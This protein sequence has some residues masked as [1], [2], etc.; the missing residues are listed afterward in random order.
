MDGEEARIRAIAREEA[1]AAIE[2][3][4]EVMGINGKARTWYLFFSE[5]L[6]AD[7][8]DSVIAYKARSTFRDE[9]LQH[10]TKS[11]GWMLVAGLIAAASAGIQLWLRGKP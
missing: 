5:T 11:T 8:R 9:F 1:K 10:V 4:D 2:A 6:P 3:H 7:A